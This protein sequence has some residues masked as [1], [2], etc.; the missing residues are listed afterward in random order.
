MANNYNV[1]AD[2]IVSK[3]VERISGEDIDETFVDDS[4]ADRVMVGMLAEN[5]MEQRFDGGYAENSSTRFESVPSISVSFA[6]KKN[7]LGVLKVIP[8]GLLFYTVEPDY[9]KTVDFLLQKYSEK[10]NV[11]Y[12]NI[13]QLCEAHPEDKFYLPLTYKKVKIEDEMKG[14]ISVPLISLQK[15]KFHLEQQ[16]NE[17]LSE[18]A[19]KISNEIKVIKSDRVSLFDLVDKER[20]YLVTGGREERVY[21]RWIIDIYCTVIDEGDSYH[22]LMQMVNKTPVNGKGN[23]GYLPKVFNAGIDVIGNRVV[24]FKNIDLD[25]FKSSYKSR[26]LVYVVAENTS[27]SYFPEDNAIRTDNIPRYYQKRLK[28]KD[29]LS[30]Y[31]KFE[32]LIQDPVGNLN[33]IYREMKADYERCAN[34]FNTTRFPSAVAKEKFRAALEEYGHEIAIFKKGIDQIE[35]KDYVKKAFIYMN[36]T[37]MTKLAGEHRQI[38]GWRLFQIVFIVSLICEMI[39]SEYKFDRNIAEADIEIANLLYFPTGGG[40]TEAFLGACVFNMFFDRLRGKNDGITA[41]LKYPL[42]LLAVQQLDRV[43]TIVM[44]ANVVR[45]SIPE[46]ACKTPFQVGFLLEKVIRQTRLMHTSA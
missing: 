46:L 18:L 11:R 26:S 35:Y 25:Y 2:Y 34:E 8:K 3:Y 14:G 6:V 17:R 7:P 44:K 12:T 31:V 27:A 32:K 5:R 43:L 39:R 19:D 4:P 21:P 23:I 16:I 9:D 15:S 29:G 22:I 30:D 1:L 20:F 38:S 13:Q 36:K 40:K 10:D 41:F 24:K 28:T 33:C 37:F 42:R 45:E